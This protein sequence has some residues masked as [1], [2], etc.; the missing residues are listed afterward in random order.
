MDSR[1]S[2]IEL[3]ETLKELLAPGWDLEAM[4]ALDQP[5]FSGLAPYRTFI[6]AV[7]YI[8][9][10]LAEAFPELHGKRLVVSEEGGGWRTFGRAPVRQDFPSRKSWKQASKDFWHRVWNEEGAPDPRLPPVVGDAK[11]FDEPGVLGTV[12]AVLGPETGEW[13]I[14]FNDEWQAVVGA[15]TAATASA[16]ERVF[17]ARVEA[18]K[19]FL[20][21]WKG[22]REHY[23][24]DWLI[25]LLR[26][27]L[28]PDEAERLLATDAHWLLE[29][30]AS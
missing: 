10:G 16:F 8:P 26:H 15:R 21:Y 23:R 2:G 27:V 17:G 4:Y 25:G 9:Q 20:D 5:Y 24:T 11:S 7:K 3:P 29:D 14:V 28:P 13:I 22:F 1:R 6:A 12:C 19:D 30:A 18:A